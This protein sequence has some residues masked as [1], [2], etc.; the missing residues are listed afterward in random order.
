[1]MLRRCRV[2]DRLRAIWGRAVLL[3]ANQI[4]TRDSDVGLGMSFIDLPFSCVERGDSTQPCLLQ[5]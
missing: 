3:F 2:D 4:P 1:M 5:V